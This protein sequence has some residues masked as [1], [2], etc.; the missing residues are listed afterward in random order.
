MVHD[1]AEA[2]IEGDV[3]RIENLLR[4]S[5]HKRHV[6]AEIVS[7]FR[8]GQERKAVEDVAEL[9]AKKEEKRTAKQQ[10]RAVGKGV[11][12][13]DARQARSKLEKPGVLEALRRIQELPQMGG[14]QPRVQ[15]VGT[16]GA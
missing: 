11:M 3:V 12:I 7:P 13:E 4:S 8:T 14:E 9:L 10:R 6:V 16:L 5:R 15:E 2:C 1:G